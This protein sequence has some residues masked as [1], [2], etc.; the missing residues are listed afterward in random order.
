MTPST[1]Q[2]NGGSGGRVVRVADLYCGAGGVAH[3]LRTIEAEHNVKFHVVGVDVEDHSDLYPGDEF[4]RADASSDALPLREDAFDVVW[5]SPPCT[6]YSRVSACQYGS[7]EAARRENPTI[8]ELGVHDVV[9]RL[10]A[11]DGVYVVENVPGAERDLE[12]PIA[13]DGGGFGAAFQMRRVFE[14]GGFDAPRYTWDRSGRSGDPSAEVTAPITARNVDRCTRKVKRAKDLPEEWPV[15]RGIVRAAIPRQYVQYLL[16]YAPDGVVPGVPLPS[17]VDAEQE[18]LDA[19][20][21]S[22]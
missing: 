8:P 20:A 3:A 19:Y 1:P 5:A 15:D 9:E 4:I 10:I 18:T 21:D 12:N 6:A 16:H 13:L 11:G 7:S 22:V 17:G 2:S 14:T